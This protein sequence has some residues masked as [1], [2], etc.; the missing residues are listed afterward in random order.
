MR[1]KSVDLKKKTVLVLILL[2]SLLFGTCSPRKVADFNIVLIVIDTLRSDHLSF[3]GYHRET[4]PFLSELAGQSIV[5]K[6]AYSASSWTSPAT[7]S[8]FTSMY[9]FQHGVLMGLLA[10]IRARKDLDMEVKVNKI[11]EEIE[12]ITE[13]LKRNNFKTYGIS[14]N[15]NIGQKQGFTQGFDRFQTF[16]YRGAERVND[17][18][19]KWK[20]DI[21]QGGQY[22]LY[23]HYMDPHAPYHHRQPF[24]QPQQGKK[25]ITIEA[26]DSEIYYV[27][28]Y[29][30]EAFQLFNWKENTL[31]IVTSDHG[32]G[33]WDHGF[34]GHGYTLYRE[35]IQ[36]PLLFYLPENKIFKEINSNVSTID[37]LPTVR[38]LAGLPPEKND[39]G[40]SLFP[41][42]EK[43]EELPDQRHLFS[44]LWRLG[45]PEREEIEFRSVVYKRMH[46]ILKLPN[47][48]E[49]YN[50]NSDTQEQS[51]RFGS[52][53]KSGRYLE[54]KFSQFLK[55]AK[56]YNPKTVFYKLSQDKLEKL[57][58]LGY[59]E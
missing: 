32:E 53:Q 35:E 12:T 50:L 39:V 58:S 17:I 56:K 54:L 9:P 55:K 27:D 11:P 51:N 2:F 21:I 52:H 28:Q 38:E 40:T 15:L 7:A 26:Y 10:V 34:M 22:F 23:L 33:L 46:Y 59:V 57:K 48:R 45:T 41:L 44:Y 8:I 43:T 4:S 19:K 6:N 31:V 16:N 37:I 13:V 29:I 3:Y 47:S 49:L 30:R 20:E 42:I 14:D 18:L 5:F 25:N 1:T 36:V 24:Y